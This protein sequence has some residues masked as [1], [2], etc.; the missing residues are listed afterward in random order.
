MA[1]P[2]VMT[3]IGRDR[4]GLVNAI[5]RKV[6]ENDG[7]WLES[8]LA[9]LAGQ[10]AGI[11]RVE[12]P[13]TRIADLS[14]ALREL[15]AHGLRV[16]VERGA[17]ALD[18]PAGANVNIELLCLDRPGIVRDVTETLTQL[19]VNIEEFES[20]PQSAAFTGAEMFH[21][22]A[23]LRIPDGLSVEELRKALER[24]AS[25]MMADITVSGDQ[26]PGA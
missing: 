10:F 21:A 15:E 11:I 3:F 17:A 19:G 12:A 26:G 24:L 4:P 1:T 5:S 25:E 13:D 23:R 22:E 7:T 16:T 20:G 6:A 2:L 18:L 9:H 8:R 14:D